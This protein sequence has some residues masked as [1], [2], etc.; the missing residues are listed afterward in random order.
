MVRKMHHNILKLKVPVD[1]KHC[2]HVVESSNQLPHDG[3]HDTRVELVV[4]EVHDFLQVVTVAQLHEDII[5][6]IG[7]NS[8][9]HFNDKLT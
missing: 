9:P 3:L 5:P 7:L 4:L 1:D 2:H 6:G 8:F